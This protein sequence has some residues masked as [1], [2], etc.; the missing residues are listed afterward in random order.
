[1]SGAT[2][3][4]A[5][6]A[7]LPALELAHKI[8]ER[9]NTIPIL[10]NVLLRAQEGTLRVTATDLDMEV[11]SACPCEGGDAA[12]TLPA[13]NL[14]E[15]VRKLPEGST[16]TLASD[17]NHWTV[18]AGRSRFR[19]RS[20]PA[21]D[22]ALMSEGSYDVEFTMPASALAE[23]LATVAHAISSEETRYYLNGPYFH[24]DEDAG[25]L[26]AVAT[27]GHRLARFPMPLPD[28]AA[29]LPAVI[30]PRKASTLFAKLSGKGDVTLSVSSTRIR[31]TLENGTT[32]TSKLIDGTYPDYRRVLPV[33]NANRFLVDRA[34]LKAAVDRVTTISAGRGSAVK[35]A[36][37]EGEVR[38]TAVNPDAGDAEET[39]AAEMLG[40]D[41]VEI[42]INGRYA[43]DLLE[44]IVADAIQIDLRD[45]GSPMLVRPRDGDE[46]MPMRV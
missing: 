11:T 8:V 34:A 33:G 46:Q 20:L 29:G 28:Q 25:Q 44:A 36:F 23:M 35:F 16:V 3:I 31:L 14:Y 4:L 42:G 26:L 41:P 32:L 19:L 1:M 27:D 18:S 22:F 6:E 9:K 38:L 37:A 12:T 17:K 30:I 24:A 40:G 45:P 5:R 10:T 43:L 7:L 15:I 21:D 2:L 13:G 39:V